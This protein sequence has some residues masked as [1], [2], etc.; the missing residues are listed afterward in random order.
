MRNYKFEED[1]KLVPVIYKK[2]HLITNDNES[3]LNGELDIIDD[4]G[5]HWETYNVDIKASESY[6]FTFPKLFE[7]GNSFPHIIDWHVNKDDSCCV[8]VTP[9][10][11]LICNRGLN[12]AD[13]IN[14]FA[15][16]YLANQSYRRKE[17]FYKNGEYAHGASGIIQFYKSK[18]KPK[19]SYELIKMFNVFLNGYSINRKEYCPFCK[20]TKFRNCHKLIFGELEPTKRF[21]LYNKGVIYEEILNNP[22]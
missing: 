20:K 3:F 11:I 2:L 22:F 16:P 17:G 14:K 1:I 19:N 18:L 9:N 8:D 12:V 15:I 6:P 10:E 4:S 7:T 13:Y 5:I 21:L